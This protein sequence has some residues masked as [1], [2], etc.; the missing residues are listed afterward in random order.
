[1]HIE[2]LAKQTSSYSQFMHA[3]V[4]QLEEI[5]EIFIERKIN[6]PELEE[7]IEDTLEEMEQII[8]DQ[9]KAAEVL[10]E[11]LKSAKASQLYEVDEELSDY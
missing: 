10:E 6:I 11:A 8:L 9:N 1:M 3:H 4:E 7:K 2:F 5:R